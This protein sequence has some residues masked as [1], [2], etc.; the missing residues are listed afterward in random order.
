MALSQCPKCGQE[1]SAEPAG[2][3]HC[4]RCGSPLGLSENIVLSS[5]CFETFDPVTK[6]RG[7]G[8]HETKYIASD[9][10]VIRRKWIYNPR[11]G[12]SSSEEEELIIPDSVVSE[13][14]LRRYIAEHRPFWLTAS[15]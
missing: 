7:G 9:R 10:K 11:S 4:P 6:T 15:R 5:R 14:E 12:K 2:A 1:I 3:A 8:G 13:E